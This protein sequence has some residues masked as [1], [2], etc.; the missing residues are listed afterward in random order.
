M[1]IISATYSEI[2]GSDLGSDTTILS[3]VTAYFPHSLLENAGIGSRRFPDT[4]F[5]IH[6]SLRILPFDGTQYMSVFLN[7]SCTVDP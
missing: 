5:L 7:L 1:S 4:F 6:Y 2:A 3:E